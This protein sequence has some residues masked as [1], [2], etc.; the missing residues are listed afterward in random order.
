[1]NEIS[2]GDKSYAKPIST[3]ML[4]DMCDDSQSHLIINSR[5]T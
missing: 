3:D 4:E 1:M 2:S 5:D